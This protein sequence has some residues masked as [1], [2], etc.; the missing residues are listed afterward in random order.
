[1]PLVIAR[2]PEDRVYHLT[3][4]GMSFTVTVILRASTVERWI[5]AIKKQFLDDAPRKC[6]GLDCEFTDPR[7]GIQN[8]RAAVFQLSVGYENLVFQICWDDEVPQLLNEFLRDKTIRFCGAAIHNDVRML[9][10]YG[11]D[12]PSVFDLQKVIPNPTNNPIPSL[13]DLSNAIIG[14]KLEK[15]KRKKKDKKKNKKDDEEEEE[16][17]LIFGWGNVPL[18]YEQVKYAAI[19]ARLGFEIARRHWKLRGYNSHVD[20]LNIIVDE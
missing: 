2:V 20:H 14:T 5:R 6:V 10:H 12:I 4:E 11:I 13:Y 7:E 9:N 15:K 16:D 18:S 8:Q 19:D 1:M 3:A 17:E